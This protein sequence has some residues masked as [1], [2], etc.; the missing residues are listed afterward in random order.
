MVSA[1]RVH[2]RKCQVKSYPVHVALVVDSPD[3]QS[4]FDAVDLVM[5]ALADADERDEAIRDWTVGF[6]SEESTLEIDL[7][8]V[9]RHHADA[10]AHGHDVVRGAVQ[11]VQSGSAQQRPVSI[12]DSDSE[13][14]V[15]A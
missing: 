7:T 10:L 2:E 4:A 14:K 3:A 6:A 8:V 1:L 15:F 5:E 9:A 13:I 11:V 12:L